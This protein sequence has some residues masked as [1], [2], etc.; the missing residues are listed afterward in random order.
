M[1]RE[2]ALAGS[3]HRMTPSVD[4]SLCV[5]LRCVFYACGLCINASHSFFYTMLT[6]QLASLVQSGHFCVLSDVF[7]GVK[8]SMVQTLSQQGQTTVVLLSGQPVCMKIISIEDAI[9]N[10]AA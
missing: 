5:S 7:C 6:G 10:L 8:F 2:P 1:F 4:L 9:C 3:L